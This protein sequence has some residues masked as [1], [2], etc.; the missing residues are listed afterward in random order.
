MHK[1]VNKINLWI[2][3]FLTVPRLSCQCHNREPF[4]ERCRPIASS[5]GSQ[6]HGTDVSSFMARATLTRQHLG[7]HLQWCIG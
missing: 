5:F 6:V 4:Q 2:V 7:V 1:K 3:I